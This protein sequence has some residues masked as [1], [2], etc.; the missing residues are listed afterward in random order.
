M[1]LHHTRIHHRPGV[2]DIFVS[3]VDARV[4]EA[5][6]RGGQK[7]WTTLKVS[8]A[9]HLER[10]I[11]AD[12]MLLEAPRGAS[13][14]FRMESDREEEFMIRH[15]P[16]G[17]TV[18]EGEHVFLLSIIRRPWLI[19]RSTA[20]FIA[21]NTAPSRRAARQA[22]ESISAALPRPWFYLFVLALLA[23]A[24]YGAWRVYSGFGAT[25]DASRV[26][27]V[28]V[29]QLSLLALLAASLLNIALRVVIHRLNE[30]FLVLILAGL[31]FG[32]FLLKG[33]AI[34][35][36]EKREWLVDPAGFFLQTVGEPTEAGLRDFCVDVRA[37]E[38]RLFEL[39]GFSEVTE[40]RA[41]C[42]PVLAALGD[43]AAALSV[44]Q[45]RAA[46]EDVLFHV[47]LIAFA[48]LTSWALI[49][50]RARTIHHVG[51][52]VWSG[53]GRMEA[54]LRTEV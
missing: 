17:L 45:K 27:A 46:R 21:H 38:Y 42:E 50:Q 15:D 22:L 10:R 16:R 52:L 6:P 20:V 32:A 54:E 34:A 44:E 30:G 41:L 24:V 14:D 51:L 53:G 35:E 48:G 40:L 13:Q 1:E 7:R 9:G 18:R 5:L 36:Y 39:P 23:A 33:P 25:Y 31:V 28:G 4:A 26:A 19:G 43:E 29:V 8:Q 12:I 3:G 37:K 47:W 11:H 2:D 49:V